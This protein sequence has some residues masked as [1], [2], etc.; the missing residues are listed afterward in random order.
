MSSDST[1]VSNGSF[2]VCFT[3]DY[4]SSAAKDM[5]EGANYMSNGSKDLYF[6]SKD[7]SDASNYMSNG[8]ICVSQ[9][10]EGRN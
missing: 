5:S 7:M 3:A 1:G 9:D 8:S 6:V 2:A 10:E 4:M